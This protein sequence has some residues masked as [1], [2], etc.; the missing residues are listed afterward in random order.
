M[1]L[2]TAK[3]SSWFDAYSSAQVEAINFLETQTALSLPPVVTDDSALSIYN[4][5]PEW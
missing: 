2:A 5:A 3:P 4:S 1:S